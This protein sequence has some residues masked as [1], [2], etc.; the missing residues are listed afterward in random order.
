MSDLGSQHPEFAWF[1]PFKE[2]QTFRSQPNEWLRSAKPDRVGPVKKFFEVSWGTAERYQFQLNTLFTC[3]LS[4]ELSTLQF[5][6]LTLT[7]DG[8]EWSEVGQS[9]TN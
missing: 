1:F 6:E 8:I 9:L 2:V 4:G 7:Q 5:S 3:Q